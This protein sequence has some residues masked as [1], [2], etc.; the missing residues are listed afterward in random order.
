MLLL[1]YILT[2]S[3]QRNRFFVNP[4]PKRLKPAE[5]FRERKG[6]IKRHMY[7]SI[8]I[9]SLNG[10]Q[11]LPQCLRAVFQTRYTDF[12]V[13]VVDNGSTDQT[14]EVVR[15]GFPQARITYNRGFAGGNNLGLKA[16]RGDMLILLN[17]DT[18]V[19]PGWLTALTNAAAQ[20]PKW[21]ILGCKLLYPD[22]RTIQ[23]AGGI[24]HPNGLTDHRGHGE[25]DQGQYDSVTPQPY[26]T[27]AAFAIRRLLLDRLGYLDQGYYPIYFEEI[28]YCVR[29]RRLAYDCLYV[30]GAVVYHAESRTTHRWSQS[31]LYKYNKNRI[32]FCLKNFTWQEL[33]RAAR[34]EMKWLLRHRPR[35]IFIPLLRA[36]AINLIKLPATLT[37]RWHNFSQLKRLKQIVADNA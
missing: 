14:R 7:V 23:H 5:V 19:E 18:E 12:E 29:A 26:V 32:R 34:S 10:A 33:L 21:G 6:H 24:I 17:D 22:K 16:A 11:V 36:Y 25:E 8:I 31:F 15:S 28:D 13:I 4:L 35:E 27:G 37:A 30:P 20:Y 9:T 1:A 2:F 3:A